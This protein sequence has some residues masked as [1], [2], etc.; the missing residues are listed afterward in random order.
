M[1]IEPLLRNI[2]EEFNTRSDNDETLRSELEGMDKKVLIDLG[3]ELYNF[4]LRDCK[5]QDFKEG[6]IEDSDL[7]ISSDPETIK[8]IIEGKI[9][10]M[11][12]FALRKI[13]FK[14]DLSDVLRLRK[15]F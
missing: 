7:I 10:P 14:G 8:G 15:L 6:R 13:R 3:N 12:A 1:T 9:K 4:H 2:V 5:A 11:K